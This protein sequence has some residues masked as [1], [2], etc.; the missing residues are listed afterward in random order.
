MVSLTGFTQN[1][2]LV[3]GSKGT[4]TIHNTIFEL[5]NVYPNPANTEAN[6]DFT[7]NASISKAQIN[8]YNLLGS[9]IKTYV[10]NENEGTLTANTS[11]LNEGI[12]FYSLVIDN[13]SKLTQK[14]IIKH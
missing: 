9:K 2:D 11:D 12:Y 14:L 5:S 7:L 3:D 4:D 6:F 1:I 8:I 13:E 10:L